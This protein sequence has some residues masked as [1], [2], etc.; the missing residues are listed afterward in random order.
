MCSHF[1]VAFYGGSAPRISRPPSLPNEPPRRPLEISRIRIS[2]DSIDIPVLIECSAGSRCVCEPLRIRQELFR[3][4][5]TV[6]KE[7]RDV[8]PA[9]ISARRIVSIASATGVC[10]DRSRLPCI[11]HPL[12]ART[13]LHPD[14]A[15]S[16]PPSSLLYPSRASVPASGSPSPCPLCTHL[17]K[18]QASSSLTGCTGKLENL[19]STDRKTCRGLLRD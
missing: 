4:K 5:T 10:R 8:V 1:S 17:A 18:R 15:G 7:I 16:G 2:G 6:D 14:D 3:I 11:I 9:R 19:A 12:W 13:L